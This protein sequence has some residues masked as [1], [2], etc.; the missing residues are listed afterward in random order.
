MSLDEKTTETAQEA[1][2]NL[3]AGVIQFREDIYPEQRELFNKLAHEQ[4]PRAMFIT[5]A[6][7]RILPDVA[8]LPETGG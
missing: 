5:C 1:L 3:I 7:S 4:T 6:D 2:D 8:A